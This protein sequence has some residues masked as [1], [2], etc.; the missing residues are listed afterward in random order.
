M[1]K[2]VLMFAAAF[3]LGAVAALLTLPP[4][5]VLESVQRVLG[6]I[7]ARDGSSPQGREPRASTHSSA[8][9]PPSPPAS[10]RNPPDGA[11]GRPGNAGTGGH[12]A[13]E[14]G[15]NEGATAWMRFSQEA[16]MILA[17]SDESAAA[18]RALRPRAE[19]GEVSLLHAYR[20]VLEAK[21]LHERLQEEA[22]GLPSGAAWTRA[23]DLLRRALLLRIHAGES[24]L[25][26]SEPDGRQR[27]E[28]ALELADQA[29]RSSAEFRAAMAQVTTPSP[30][31]ATGR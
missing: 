18:L 4:A 29:D 14:A 20:A 24:L 15:Q 31:P 9:H 21:A 2:V 30:P 8:A 1:R 25:D 6:P 22:D 7:G 23:H 28:R 16:P 17:R 26:G 27:L 11:A 3:G 10:G 13:D 19:T 12:S 5:S